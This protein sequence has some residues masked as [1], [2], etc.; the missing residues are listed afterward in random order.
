MDKV[1]CLIGVIVAGIQPRSVYPQELSDLETIIGSNEL[2]VIPECGQVSLYT[3]LRLENPSFSATLDEVAASVDLRPAG[4]SFIELGNAAQKFGYFS[5]VC[6]LDQLE[7]YDREKPYIVM[8]S[9]N[10]KNHLSVVVPL[11][12]QF[13]VV[14]P[15]EPIRVLDQEQFA[16]VV[17]L[18]EVRFYV[19]KRNFFRSNRV[20]VAWCLASFWVILILVACYRKAFR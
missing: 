18:P 6:G 11:G 8:L 7:K 4:T 17:V 12:K 13:C 20:V 14:D 16:K 10:E 19:E 15:P 9:K 2:R 3:L 5:S 1:C